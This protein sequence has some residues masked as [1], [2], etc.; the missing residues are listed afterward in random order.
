M[1]DFFNRYLSNKSSEADFES[2][3]ELLLSD[4]KEEE[5]H[6]RMIVDW[7]NRSD[8]DTSVDLTPVL[9]N[10]H[11][12]I[13]QSEKSNSVPNK[14]IR[15]L[16]RIAA[17]LVIPLAFGLFYEWSSLSDIKFIQT[18]S[19]P[20]ASR[21]SLILPDGSKVWLNAGSTISFPNRFG[22]TTRLVQ[23][24]GQAYFDVKK[25]D[26]PFRVETKNFSVKVLGTAFDVFAY[27]G[28]N[29][30]VTLERG[31]VQLETI[32][33][34][35]A[36]L[37]PGQQAIINQSD[38]QIQ[39]RNVDSKAFVSWKENRLTFDDLPLEKVVLCLE[40]WFN[41]NIAIEDESIR[42]L[43]VNGRIEYENII[44]VLDLL[45]MTA[46]IDYS[47]DKEKQIFR[48]KAKQ[49]DQKK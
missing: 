10:V 3:L 2:F 31:K 41:V 22:K 43:K 1:S 24:V 42:F 38:G 21:T 12:R 30:E 13:N 33:N 14:F 17:I 18:V 19:T 40:R 20:M 39:K 27:Q 46:P 23:L 49:L 11:F 25:D 26:I 37:N 8:T 35:K 34:V 5:L 45:K 28:E 47:Y 16:T 48:L 15:Y 6:E 44:E 4:S 36:D 32:M 9:C 29:A 7:E